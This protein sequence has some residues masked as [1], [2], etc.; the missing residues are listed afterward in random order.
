MS[1]SVGEYLYS[2]VRSAHTIPFL[3]SYYSALDVVADNDLYC[4]MLRNVN[5]M[6]IVIVVQ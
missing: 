6:I 5:V 4:M 2:R 3:L 1:H